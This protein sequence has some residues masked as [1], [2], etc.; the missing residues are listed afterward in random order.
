VLEGKSKRRAD[1][2]EVYAG[3]PDLSDEAE[4]RAEFNGMFEAIA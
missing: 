1:L 3:D 2:A 4:L